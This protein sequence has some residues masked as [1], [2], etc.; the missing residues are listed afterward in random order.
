MSGHLLYGK[1]DEQIRAIA[2]SELQSNRKTWRLLAAF[3]YLAPGYGLI[4]APVG[5]DTGSASVPRWPLTFVLQG[6]YDQAAA[7]IHDWPY[8]SGELS[9]ADADRVLHEALR[10]SGIVAGRHG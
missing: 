10:S 4:D 5:F 8:S 6:S 9:R 7:V 1:R 3:S 2:A